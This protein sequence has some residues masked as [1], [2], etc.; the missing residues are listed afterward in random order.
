MIQML[1]GRRIFRLTFLKPNITSQLKEL[2][3]EANAITIESQYFTEARRPKISGL[4]RNRTLETV[5]L[6]TIRDET[7]FFGSRFIEELKKAEMGVK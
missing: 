5:D 1:K 6:G 3:V 4:M 2:K 7:R